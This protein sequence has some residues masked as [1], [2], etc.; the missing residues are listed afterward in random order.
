MVLGQVGHR[1]LRSSPDTEYHSTNAPHPYVIQLAAALS[2]SATDIFR[3]INY[4]YFAKNA[5]IFKFNVYLTDVITF[6]SCIA[7]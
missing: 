1:V 7:L 5:I 6:D 3:K 2:H 4:E